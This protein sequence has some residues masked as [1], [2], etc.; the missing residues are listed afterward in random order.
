M[1]ISVCSLGLQIGAPQTEIG[2]LTL[3][4]DAPPGTLSQ[5]RLQIAMTWDFPALLK[6]GCRL[7]APSGDVY[8][9]TSLYCFHFLSFNDCILKLSQ[10]IY[11]N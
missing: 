2:S 3:G 9:V 5:E 11:K 4:V 8:A 6:S 10:I 7:L 1:M